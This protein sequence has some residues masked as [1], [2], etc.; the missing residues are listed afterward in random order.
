MCKSRASLAQG[1]VSLVLLNSSSIDHDLA[2][3]PQLCPCSTALFAIAAAAAVQRY[4]HMLK[5]LSNYTSNYTIASSSMQHVQHTYADSM[6][7]RGKCKIVSSL[8]EGSKA[9]L[10]QGSKVNL[11]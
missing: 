6:I 11:A 4:I 3:S 1:N 5:Q 10:G 8:L 2:T 7:G 9:D